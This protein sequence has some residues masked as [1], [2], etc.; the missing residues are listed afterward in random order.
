MY[1]LQFQCD[2]DESAGQGRDSGHHQ[3]P[4]EGGSQ[5]HQD[6]QRQDPGG[7]PKT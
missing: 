1:R 3:R 6:K 2:S 4:D 5:H 7:K